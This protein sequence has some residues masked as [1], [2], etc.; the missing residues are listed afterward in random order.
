[1]ILVTLGSLIN[2]GLE[3]VVEAMELMAPIILFPITSILKIMVPS[4]WRTLIDV[5]LTKP[6]PNLALVVE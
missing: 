3:I 4:M 6:K 5:K 1:M 2:Q